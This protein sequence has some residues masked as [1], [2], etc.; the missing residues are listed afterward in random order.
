M[1][2]VVEVLDMMMLED[3]TI[4]QW[5][6]KCYKLYWNM[7]LTNIASN[8]VDHI[9]QDCEAQL[10]TKDINTWW[11]MSGNTIVGKAAIYHSCNQSQKHEQEIMSRVFMK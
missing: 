6:L 3:S 4:S 7:E 1:M 2:L 8:Q 10:L 5:I 11:L 9:V